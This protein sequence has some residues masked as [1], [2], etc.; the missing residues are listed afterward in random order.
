[1]VERGM[2]EGKFL[3]ATQGD[4]YFVISTGKDWYRVLEMLFNTDG[5]QYESVCSDRWKELVEV[6]G[7]DHAKKMLVEAMPQNVR[8]ALLMR[9]LE[10]EKQLRA[11]QHGQMSMDAFTR[12]L[13]QAVYVLL[14]WLGKEKQTETFQKFTGLV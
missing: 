14:N 13:R 5:V 10:I 12:S 2:E 6:W 11:M 8:A 9:Y 1:M 4:S 3:V 7:M